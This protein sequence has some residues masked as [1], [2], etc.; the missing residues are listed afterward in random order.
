[1]IAP[2]TLAFPAVGQKTVNARFDGGDLTSDAGLLFIA[3]AD[4]RLGLTDKMARALGDCRQTSKVRFD[5]ATLLK[6]RIYAI[7]AGYE[8]CND[9]DTLKDDPGLRVACGK[10]I[11]VLQALASQPTLSRFENAVT[12]RDLLRLGT[13]LSQ[14]AVAQLPKETKH[15]YLDLDATVDPTHGQQELSLFDGHY[16]T[17]CYLPLLAFVTEE[18]GTQHLIG[19]LLRSACGRS[20]K[21]VLWMVRKAVRILR[22]HFPAIQITVRGDCGFGYG[23]LI[24]WCVR[25]GVGYLL[26]VQ[27][28]NPMREK[29]LWAQME[30]AVWHRFNAMDFCIYDEWMHK[31]EVW[32]KPTRMIVKASVDGSKVEPRFVVTHSSEGTAEEVYRCYTQRGDAENRIKEF[33]LD[34]LSGRTSCHRFLAN[35]FRLLLHHAAAILMKA[36]QLAL[37][38]TGYANAQVNTVRVRLLKVAAR[39]V[40]SCR[41]IWFHLPTSFPLHDLWCTLSTRLWTPST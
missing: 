33:K 16:D 31:A 5:L 34:L 28:T 3:Q 27:A 36:L 6:E 40:V 32:D 25:A 8:D 7:A 29:A 20:T 19:A 35:V 15:V 14:T 37:R 26:A 17:W 39:V 21:G 30:V 24:N 11:H 12:A 9:L 41:R 23:R 2:P 38:G 22:A 10:D 1:M 18:S 13:L 4:E